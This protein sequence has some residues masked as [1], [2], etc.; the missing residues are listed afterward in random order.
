LIRPA[1]LPGI[2][3]EVESNLERKLALSYN[4]FKNLAKSPSSLI[5]RDPLHDPTFEVL[6]AAKNA[7]KS[8][9]NLRE[10]TIVLHDHA[11]TPLFVSFLGSMWSS[12][13]LGPT[14]RKLTIDTTVVK[15]PQ[16]LNPL[17]KRPG[18][19]P[20]LVEFNVN[21]SIS[22]L[23]ESRTEWR[24]ARDVIQSFLWEFRRLLTSFALSSLVLC[25]LAALFETFPHISNL[26]KFEFRGIFNSKTF[27]YTDG[28]TEFIS[29]QRSHLD[30]LVIKPQTRQLSINSSDT[31]YS[32]WVNEDNIEH[33]S[34]GLHSFSHL[35]LPKLKVLNVG[36]RDIHP[37]WPHGPPATHE[38][39]NQPL[40]PNLSRVT[41]KLRAL[42]ITDVSLSYLRVSSLVKSLQR[43]GFC[44][45]EELNFICDS[46]SPQLFDLLSKHLPRLK[47]LTVQFTYSA[48]QPDFQLVDGDESGGGNVS[49]LQ[50][51]VFLCCSF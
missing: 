21:I 6:D 38:A 37:A 28:F 36:L 27:P 30:H 7:V 48:P 10:I 43:E 13:S 34:T 9:P 19:L 18:A 1:F 5:S 51:A 31:T 4:Y 8:C 22:R 49:T 12:G 47:L 14:L 50:V 11:L 39:R 3:E 40:L 26:K 16:L 20:N 46:L 29:K 35:V 2:D 42:I 33:Q 41:P 32:F 25:D 45:L 17:I 15:L 44:G 24:L 23:E